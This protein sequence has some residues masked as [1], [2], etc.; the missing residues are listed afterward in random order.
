METVLSI[1]RFTLDAQE[2]ARRAA[3][4]MQRYGHHQIDTEHV[5]L[6]LVEQPQDGM[7]RLLELLHVDAQAL[8]GEL[9]RQLRSGPEG[10]I[11]KVGEGQ[12]AITPRVA[13]LLDLADQEARQRNDE[14]ISSGH[15]FLEI[16]QEHDTPAAHLLQGM[17]LTR[18][19][20]DEALRQMPR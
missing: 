11:M 13:H 5:L 8:G 15:I 1:D 6:A 4:I 17:A 7:S 16:F 14:R 2:T 12:V 3:E 9:D 20:V 10:E 18:E 19:R